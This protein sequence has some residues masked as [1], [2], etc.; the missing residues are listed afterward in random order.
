MRLSSPSLF[1]T[2]LARR[3]LPG[4]SLTAYAKRIAAINGKRA[5]VDP[6]R[7]SDL[8]KRPKF[9]TPVAA[10]VNRAQPILIETPRENYDNAPP[11]S[12]T[13]YGFIPAGGPAP[14]AMDQPG[15]VT[16]PTD[17]AEPVADDQLAIAG[18]TISKRT[19]WIVGGAV[20]IA[21]FLIV[22]RKG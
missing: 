11:K 7:A 21:L 17:V 15:T 14:L 10:P 19:A 18:M 6:D 4:E 12:G 3:R 22:R 16:M 2:P 13:S 8:P 1:A 9:A 5:D 20:L